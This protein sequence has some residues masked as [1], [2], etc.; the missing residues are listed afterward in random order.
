VGR[1]ETFERRAHLGQFRPLTERDL[2]PE[3]GH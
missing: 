3:G 2:L 1:L